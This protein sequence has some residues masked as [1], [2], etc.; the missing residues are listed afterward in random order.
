MSKNS[1]N[2]GST[3]ERDICKQLSLWLTE[4]KRDDIFWRTAA[5]GGRA[6][7]RAKVSKKTSG[8]YG[9]INF[10]D[11]LGEGLLKLFCFELKRGYKDLS[12][13]SYIDRRPAKTKTVLEEFW[14]QAV[15]SAEQSGAHF[16]LV[17]F[18]RDLHK[19]CVMFPVEFFSIA[20]NYFGYFL[21]PTAKVSFQGD[22]GFFTLVI[23]T[24]ES[25]LEY[26]NPNVID[27]ILADIEDLG[28]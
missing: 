4:G 15:T 19:P 11:P 21:Y 16:P 23:T 5:S 24:M 9:D 17:I 8:G 22:D 3:F 1:K 6:T 25:F 26:V 20:K 14:D 28:R 18:K 27:S 10:L 2:K 7:N 12:V 13:L